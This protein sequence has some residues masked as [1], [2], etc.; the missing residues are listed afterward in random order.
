MI[1]DALNLFI[2][3]FIVDPSL[4]RNGNPIGGIK[5]SLKSL[6]KLIRTV[7]PDEIAFVWDGPGGSRKKK[8][9][10]KEYKEG[11]KPIRLNRNIDNMTLDQ[12][13]ENKIWQQFRLFEMLNQLP[14]MQFLEQDIEADDL[15]A[16]VARCPKYDDWGKI[17]VSSD[18]DFIQLLDDKTMLYRPIQEEIKTWKNVVKEYGIHPTNFALAR[19]MAGDKSDNLTGVH[20]I[21]LKSVAKNLPMLAEDKTF[22]IPE[23]EEY[24]KKKVE[25]KSKL[26]FFQTVVDNIEEIR[27]HYAIMQLY[28][29]QL[30]VQVAQ[31]ARYVTENFVPEVNW[32]QFQKMANEDGFSEVDFTEMMASFRRI[33]R[34]HKK[35]DVQDV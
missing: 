4:G 7:N 5:G 20:G 14:I 29:P 31:K 21:G 11:R 15:I 17:I 32:T 27:K 6:Q 24:C 22:L 8:T 30:S 1:V 18:K 12:E 25:E 33:I 26:K 13:S 10:F 19:A 3:C 34:D 16:F 28:A 2:R 23:L 9:Q 35:N